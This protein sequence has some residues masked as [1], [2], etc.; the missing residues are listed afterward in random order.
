MWTSENHDRTTVETSRSASPKQ[1]V[2]FV[3]DNVSVSAQ[4]SSID[5]KQD[6]NESTCDY[7]DGDVEKTYTSYSNQILEWMSGGD[8]LDGSQNEGHSDSGALLRRKRS[9]NKQADIQQRRQLQLQ[10]VQKKRDTS[11]RN[12]DLVEELFERAM[13]GRMKAM[14]R[15]AADPP[16]DRLIGHNTLQYIP[17]AMIK[18][19]LKEMVDYMQKESSHGIQPTEPESPPVAVASSSVN[20]RGTWSR[21]TDNAIVF[22]TET[23]EIARNGMQPKL[24]EEPSSSSNAKDAV[25]EDGAGVKTAEPSSPEAVQSPSSS[26]ALAQPAEEMLAYWRELGYDTMYVISPQTSK[27]TRRHAMR[28]PGAPLV[29]SF[30]ASSRGAVL[31]TPLAPVGMATDRRG[32]CGAK[33]DPLPPICLL[34][35]SV[36]AVQPLDKRLGGVNVNHKFSKR[37][38]YS[39]DNWKANK[40]FPR[41]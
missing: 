29:E 35:R 38:D 1:V 3:E 8:F 22:L 18:G 5:E 10:R 32:G 27:S 11:K 30:S 23:D 4:D 9:L 19:Q 36:E 20:P 33:L 24:P 14:Q 28:T 40:F 34:Q 41:E 13:A 21:E 25:G 31:K 12:F 6:L 26:S 16:A 37:K 2:N 39:W 7:K 17:A 15:I